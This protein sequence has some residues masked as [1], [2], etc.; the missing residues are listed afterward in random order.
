MSIQKGRTNSWDCELGA[1]KCALHGKGGSGLGLDC[2]RFTHTIEVNI[3]RVLFVY[4]KKK[5][6][7]FSVGMPF[8]LE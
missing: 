5:Q 7:Y 3:V 6:L 2:G 4:T 1:V 8:I